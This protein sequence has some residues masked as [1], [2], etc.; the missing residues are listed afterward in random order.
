MTHPQEET[1]ERDA[2]LSALAW[3]LPVHGYVVEIEK[4]EL[5]V[6]SPES[7]VELRI[8]CAPRRADGDRLWFIADREPPIGPLPE[9]MAEASGDI[10]WALVAVKGLMQERT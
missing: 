4:D 2:R 5:R 10:M 9:P 3:A 1:A 6:T 7:G 8:W